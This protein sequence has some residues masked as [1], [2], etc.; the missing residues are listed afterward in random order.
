MIKVAAVVCGLHSRSTA[1]MVGCG[2]SGDLMWGMLL[3]WSVACIRGQLQ[4]NGTDL[5]RS[6]RILSS[7]ETTYA[8]VLVYASW[9]PFS[10]AL[11]PLFEY[12]SSSFPSIY[13]FAL[14]ESA[15]QRSAFSH[16]GASSYPVLFLHNKTAK[17]RY[18]GKRTFSA[19]AEFYEDY[20]GLQP[21]IH[22]FKIVDQELSLKQQQQE[23]PTSLSQEGKLHDDVYLLLSFIFLLSRGLFYLLPKLSSLFKHYWVGKGSWH[24]YQSLFHGVVF[25]KFQRKQN[26]LSVTKCLKT[27]F[28]QE[29]GKVL[30]GVPGWPSSSLAAVSFAEGSRSKHGVKAGD[31]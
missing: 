2:Q 15:L 25:G 26:T 3:L 18:Q 20:S 12:L 23:L 21:V 19:I 30:L 22:P 16:Y 27:D 10:R 24:T 4:V 6:L 14:E 5:Q 29:K 28:T 1:G 8:A 11:R 17:I 7:Q 13:H 31:M 9:C